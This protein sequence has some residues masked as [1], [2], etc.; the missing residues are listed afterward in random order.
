MRESDLNLPEGVTVRGI[1]ARVEELRS[2]RS[3][4]QK[5]FDDMGHNFNIRLYIRKKKRETKR[6]QVE[7]A[8]EASLVELLEIQF[9]G[10]NLCWDLKD[11][12]GVR[13]RKSK[14]EVSTHDTQM[15]ELEL[16]RAEIRAKQRRLEKG[17]ED[18]FQHSLTSELEQDMKDEE[19]VERFSH[20]KEQSI[21]REYPPDSEPERNKKMKAILHQRVMSYK[22]KRGWV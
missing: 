14:Y 4:L 19:D 2:D 1:L 13:E 9:K 11:L 5:Y 15:M 10:K 12:D 8:Y 21:D 3:A 7:A 20:R 17:E 16:K 18:G 6:V 22:R